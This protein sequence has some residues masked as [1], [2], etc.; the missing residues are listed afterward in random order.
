M[1]IDPLVMWN[2]DALI[3]KPGN[4]HAT[5]YAGND[6]MNLVDTSGQSAMI[7]SGMIFGSAIVGGATAGL[8]AYALGA[9]TKTIKIVAE[10]GVIAGIATFGGGKFATSAVGLTGINA[11]IGGLANIATQCATGTPIAKLNVRSVA[12]GAIAGGIGSLGGLGAG[13]SAFFIVPVIGKEVTSTMARTAESI[14]SIFASGL[15]STGLEV[16]AN[17][18]VRNK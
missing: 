4:W 2:P 6:P 15:I 8:T 12:I 11:L 13:T 7:A 16:G 3:D 10:I 17:S 5:R 1:T 14:T 9:D 18:A